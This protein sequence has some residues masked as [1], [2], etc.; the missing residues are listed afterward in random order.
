MPEKLLLDTDVIIEYLRGR[1]E[2]VRYLRGRPEAVRYL[3][4]RPEAVRYLRGRPE[5]VRYL[6]GL[7]GTLLISAITVAELYVGVRGG[8]EERQLE[9]FLLAF[10]VV[11]ISGDIGRIG[12]LFRRD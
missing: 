9:Q 10:D 3:R 5:A 8:S 6:Q 4:G 7:E 11:P 12:G 1:P 2:A